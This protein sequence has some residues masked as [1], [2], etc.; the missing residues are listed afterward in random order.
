MDLV[1]LPS[2]AGSDR[3]F[4]FLA[5]VVVDGVLAL[6]AG[7]LGIWG[8]LA[9]QAKIRNIVLTHSHTDHV[10][11]LPV[12]LENVYGLGPPV[13]V[14]GLPET[15]DS[16]RRDI[17]NDRLFPDLLTREPESGQFVKFDPLSPGNSRKLGCHTVSL[18]PVCHPVPTAAVHIDSGRDS[19]LYITDTAPTDAVWEYAGKLRNL[20]AVFLEVTF[21]DNLGWLAELSGHLTPSQFAAEL[22]KVQTGVDVF[23]IHLKPRYHDAVLRDLA[24]LKLGGVEV[25]TPGKVYSVGS[26]GK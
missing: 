12:F 16:V 18:I 20:R 22:R 19:V 7:A 3:G 11:T 13:T 26:Q 17:F 21:P 23:A 9:A 8:N 1:L 14:H 25:V 15:L 5:T 4:Q 24:A 6:D 2:S 10:A